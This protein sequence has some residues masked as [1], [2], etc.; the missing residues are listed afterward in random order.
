MSPLPLSSNLSTFNHSPVQIA[1]VWIESGNYYRPIIDSDF[2]GKVAN[3]SGTI[4]STSSGEYILNNSNYSTLGFHICVPSGGEISFYGSFDGQNYDNITLRQL[5]DDGYTQKATYSNNIC[6]Y[7]YIGSISA[8]KTVKFVNTITG[9]GIG[10]VVGRMSSQV[11]T[12][13]GIEHNAPPHKIGNTPFHKGIFVNNTSVTGQVIYQ[14]PTGYRFVITDF[15]LSIFSAGANI[16]LYEN[17]DATD[18]DSWIFSVYVKA[19]SNDTQVFNSN[20]STP[21]LAN[22]ITAPLC[23]CAD[24]TSTVRGVVH[25]YYTL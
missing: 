15:N 22:S 8:L 10:Y 1:G 12:L 2:N 20:L 7:N 21:Y 9:N 18:T 25:G 16:T 3:F 5:G 14:P 23:I 17:G 4:P 19:T 6:D 13:E 11:S 24:A